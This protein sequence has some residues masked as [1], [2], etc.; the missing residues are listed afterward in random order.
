MQITSLYKKIN[1][2]AL[3]AFERAEPNITVVGI[4]SL[5]GFPLFYFIWSYLLPQPY[6]NI[7]YRLINSLIS[8]PCLFYKHFS[9]KTK[10]YF[11]IYFFIG[12]ILLLPFFFSFMLYKNAW[13]I[14]WFISN[15]TALVLLILLIDDWSLIFLFSIAGY[16]LAFFTVWFFDGQIDFTYFQW[17]YIPTFLFLL[18]G[19]VI[20]SHRK[21]IAHQTKLSLLHSLS[22][23]IAHEMRN[24]LNSIITAMSSVQSI[25][26]DKPEQDEA[27]S[28]YTLSRSRMINLHDVVEEST[29]TV[30]R[31]NKIIDTILT[32]MQGRSLDPKIFK[33][34]SAKNNINSAIRSFSYSKPEDRKL[35]RNLASIDFVFL[36]DKDLLTYVLFNLIKNALYYK[37][38]PDFFLEVST[39]TTA[40]WN[41]IKVRD[42][43]PGI[44]VSEREKIFDSFYTSG[45]EDGIGLGLSFCK[46]V[47]TSF[48]GHIT[49][50]SKENEWTEFII[51]LPFYNSKE[52]EKLKKEILHTKNI[53]VINNNTKNW[54]ITKKYLREWTCKV[55]HAENEDQANFLLSRQK[56]DLILL[57][58]DTINTKGHEKIKR[59]C[60]GKHGCKKNV[61]EHE[62]IPII[63]ISALPEQELKQKTLEIGISGYIVKPLTREHVLS[64]FEDL[65]F[66]ESNQ[67]INTNYPLLNNSNI[68]IVDDN[69]TSR[70]FISFILERMGARVMQ[71]E[72][73]EEALEH[74]EK[75]DYELIFMDMEMPVLNGINTTRIIREGKRFKRFGK[76]REI[77]IIA[78]TGNTDDANITLAKQSGMNDHLGKPFGKEDLTRVLSTWLKK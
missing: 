28:A 25:L 64:V 72:N 7:T 15:L 66:S 55:Q 16:T 32:D 73:G 6:E 76:Y 33:K 75:N 51:R 59:I 44:P 77:P 21:H 38:N 63:G 70:K 62:T 49:C 30:L 54:L 67:T 19:G 2:K 29:K 42:T 53:L 43:G 50:D 48:A 1:K 23:S 37:K 78:L 60:I 20:V 8:L 68:L 39:G 52:V 17:M 24:P 34:V 14:T 35:I 27:I 58:I 41:F 13:N 26:P 5:F 9:G 61:A 57:D 69:H 71:A 74:L 22:A 36:G 56:F 31:A 46:H 65:F 12:V 40:E 47:I 3:E 11:P 45:K 10:K 18:I 4:F